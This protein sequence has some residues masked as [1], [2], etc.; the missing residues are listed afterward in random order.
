MK[1]RLTQRLAPLQARLHSQWHA[2]PAPGLWQAWLRELRGSLPASWRDRLLPQASERPIRW[3]SPEGIASSA[4]E[5]LV[6]LLPADMVLAQTLPLPLAAIRDLH[7]V[8]GFELDK[9]T[10]F[11]RERMHYVARLQ[12]RGKT[13]AQVLL[14]AIAHERLAHVLDHCRERGLTLAGVDSLD[15]EGL[16]LG[17]DLLPADR[18]PPRAGHYRLTRYLTL[19]CMALTL[20]CMLLWLHARS[21]RLAGMQAAVAAQREDVRQVQALR[22]ELANT[23]GAARYLAQ[24]KAAR[25]TLTSVL[26]DLTGC[27]G[28]DTWVEQLEIAEDG[29]LSISGQSAK[30]STLITRVKACQT[31]VDARFQGIIQPDKETAKER[32][33]LRAQLRKEPADAP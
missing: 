6:L 23:Q 2:S 16:P 24:Q 8:V 11:P 4:G 3:P 7:S 9:Y 14:V 1:Q 22:Q 31:L 5:R 28:P 10:P 15:R 20:A 25:P 33:S 26:L 18:K 19:G 27:L 12:S 29:T 21:D 17:I 30:A 13:L 32:F